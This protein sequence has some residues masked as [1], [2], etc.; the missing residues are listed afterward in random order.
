MSV[1]GK[2]AEFKGLEHLKGD[3]YSVGSG[4][5]GGLQS[6]WQARLEGW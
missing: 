1:E 5:D 2:G 6:A 3:A 4:S